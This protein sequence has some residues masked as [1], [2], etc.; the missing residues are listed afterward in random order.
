MGHWVLEKGHSAFL[1]DGTYFHRLGKSLDLGQADPSLTLGQYG[2]WDDTSA[3]GR[4]FTV[5]ISNRSD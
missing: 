4:R 3:M 2:S 1:C 5:E